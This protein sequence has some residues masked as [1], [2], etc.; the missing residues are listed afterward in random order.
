MFAL[1]S[2]SGWSLPNC[3]SAYSPY[4]KCNSIRIVLDI[5]FPFLL[6]VT[7]LFAFSGTEL[8]KRCN[9]S[10]RISTVSIMK[11]SHYPSCITNFMLLCV[12][13][14][15]TILVNF[16]VQQIHLKSHYCFCVV[17][18]RCLSNTA[19]HISIHIIPLAFFFTIY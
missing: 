4:Y 3:K 13:Y 6:T 5:V 12:K 19:Q 8:N 1:D 16:T 15:T 17:C 11:L 7:Y 10:S 14:I 9:F 18:H 2:I